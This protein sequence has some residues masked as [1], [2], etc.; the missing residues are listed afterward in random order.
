MASRFE[1]VDEEDIEELM[2][3]SENENK[4]NGTE[5]WK[6]VFKKWAIERNL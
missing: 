1:T 2:D 4:K 6:N 5:R 3:K